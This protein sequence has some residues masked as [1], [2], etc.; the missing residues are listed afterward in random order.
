[1]YDVKYT[2]NSQFFSD[3]WVI[4]SVWVAAYSLLAWLKKQLRPKTHSAVLSVVGAPLSGLVD[5][6]NARPGVLLKK[7][8]PLRSYPLSLDR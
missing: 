8:Q 1:M 6:V 3:F 2:A 5:V 4:L 7:S